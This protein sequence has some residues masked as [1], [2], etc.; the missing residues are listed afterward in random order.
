MRDDQNHKSFQDPTYSYDFIAIL[1]C[2]ISTFFVKL[3]L[4]VGFSRVW[5]QTLSDVKSGTIWHHS[6]V[7][8]SEYVHKLSC[9]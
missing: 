8:V 3:L 1:N 5:R 2:E 9:G 6:M 4:R 7:S